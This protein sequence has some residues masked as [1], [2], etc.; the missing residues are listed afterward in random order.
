MSGCCMK[1]D[2]EVFHI[3]AFSLQEFLYV[4][5]LELSI[6]FQP[7]VLMKEFSELHF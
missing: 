3:S 6:I 7:K 1:W 2:N 5:E 4:M